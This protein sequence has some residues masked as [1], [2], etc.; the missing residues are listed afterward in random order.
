MVQINFA[1]REINCKIVYYGPGKSGKTTNLE[2]VHAKAPGSSKGELVSIAT[3]TDRTLYFDFLPLDLGKV[4]GMTTKFQL[5]TVPGQVFYNATRKLV[6][7]G[8]D[9]V[10]FVADSQKS[11]RQENIDSL[12]NLEE[13]L[14]ENG[15]DIREIPLVLQWN[16]RDLK[17][18][19]T[20]EE[21]EEDMNSFGVPTTE[22]IAVN[23]EGV[24][25]TLKKLSSLVI[26]KL[27]EETSTGGSSSAPPKK[28]EPPAKTE[29]EKT[30]EAEK[31]A[32]KKAPEPPQPEKKPQETPPEKEKPE[33]PQP[34][35][36]PEPIK[37][38]PESEKTETP[39]DDQENLIAKELA[40]R[41]EEKQQKGEKPTP[42][43]RKEKPVDTQPEKKQPEKKKGFLG[44]LF[45]I[46]KK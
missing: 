23:G 42:P 41:R 7:Q 9:G 38:P 15:L 46:F 14:K 34:E 2:Q 8:A 29:S 40:R 30:P 12:K 39:V 11:M 18:I 28:E 5:Y 31:P 22:A 4:A 25:P 20:A 17:D 27:N 1:S 10:I 13:N 26:K 6:L 21:M 36:K 19:M 44:R 32:E 35:P 24:F 43:A 16:K 33:P 45:R 37:T 3:E